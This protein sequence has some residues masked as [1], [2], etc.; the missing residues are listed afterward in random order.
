[1]TKPARN[2]IFAPIAE[3]LQ[4]LILP[5]VSRSSLNCEKKTMFAKAIVPG[6]MP[7]KL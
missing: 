7:K 4:Q 1:L 2:S 6:R 5:A 3:A